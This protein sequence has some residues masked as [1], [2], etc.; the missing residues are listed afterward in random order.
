[1]P[2]QEIRLLFFNVKLMYFGIGLV[3]L[4]VLQ[5]PAGNAGGHLAHIGGAAL[6]YLYATQL[7]K[8]M[9]LGVLL[10]VFG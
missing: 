3:V 1:M 2:Y 6:G 7:Q 8:E 4:D 9:I 10:S 5:I